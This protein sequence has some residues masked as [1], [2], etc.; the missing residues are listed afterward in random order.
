VSAGDVTVVIPTTASAVRAESLKRA[1]DSVLGQRSGIAVRPMVVANGRIYDE[2]LLASLRADARLEFH[3]LEEG[4]L[5]KAIH[6][7]RLQV[8]TPF[9][10]FLDDDDYL[11]PDAIA[12]R[13][14]LIDSGSGYDA[15]VTS[16]YR[17]VGG[18]L[19]PI[20]FDAARCARGPAEMLAE[21][22]WLASCAGLFRT[23][24]I[25][26]DYFRDLQKYAEWTDV[27]YRLVRDQTIGFS[28]AKTFVIEFSSESLSQNP[29]F[30]LAPSL[31][32]SRL[33]S[34]GLPR[35]I[36]PAVE[37]KLVDELHNASDYCRNEGQL[38]KA[39]GF[40]LRSI[41][42]R[43]GLRYIPYTRHLLFGKRA[44]APRR[45]DD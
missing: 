17:S 30:R 40:H 21:R 13:L 4:S 1:I 2:G 26:A 33:L 3:Y 10:G 32:L 9:F 35:D 45:A 42:F 15:A 7:G 37:R 19:T 6:Y 39:W 43:S 25:G 16:G 27:A 8:R 20:E 36:R 18:A 29:A 14:D 12:L 31:L 23:A 34:E 22:N 38:L 41:G 44:E 11:T 24:A 5:P 28:D